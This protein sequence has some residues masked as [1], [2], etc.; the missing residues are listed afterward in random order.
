MKYSFACGGI[1]ISSKLINAGKHSPLRQISVSYGEYKVLA[2]YYSLGKDIV[3]MNAEAKWGSKFLHHLSRDL[4]EQ[5]PDVEG[6]SPTNLLYIK[7]FYILYSNLLFTPQ[8]G[9]R[10][11]SA[12][13]KAI[14][15]DPYN[16]AFAGITGEYN[17]KLLKNALLNN[18]T[19][20]LLE[21]GTGFAYVG[22]E[23]RLEIGET[24]NFIDL[25]FYH[26]Q[27]RCYV[28][29]EVKTDK[30]TFRDTGQLSGY[31]VACN[32]ILKRPDDNPTIGL[33]ICKSK[34]DTIAQYALEGCSQ[35]IGISAYDLEK[36]YPTKVEGLIPTIEESEA[37]L[38]E[39][40]GGQDYEQD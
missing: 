34:D 15:R 27:L 22:K 26:L 38:N 7:N 25:L 29:I 20:F 35:P 21:L 4:K 3:E 14:T 33:L 11:T 37:K 18:I 2:F 16:F 24:E 28:V 12:L 9:E 17:E 8:P 36:L 32:H 5:L 40:Q 31:V 6:F 23:Y 10:M 19:N 1:L 39:T 13:A 30:M